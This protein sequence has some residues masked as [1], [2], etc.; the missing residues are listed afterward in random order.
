M[1]RHRPG[2]TLRRPRKSGLRS[3][4]R[5]GAVLAV[6]QFS[7]LS[8]LWADTMLPPQEVLQKLASQNPSEANAGVAQAIHIG[9]PM[10]PWLLRLRDRKEAFSGSALLNPRVSM[11]MPVQ[12]PGFELPDSEKYRVVSVEAAALYLVSAIH[13]GDLHFAQA[14][15]L[16]DP[17][18]S[19]LKR[20]IANTPERLGRAFDAAQIWC[21]EQLANGV[22]RSP[23]APDPIS[24]SGLRW[25]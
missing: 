15:L 11:L 3:A 20:L 10:I 14:A 18:E 7:L 17:S 2:T 9:I 25:Y 13:H 5:R 12:L 8:Q 24:A 21:R 6:L 16:L 19:P 4:G 22:R 1:T 23:H